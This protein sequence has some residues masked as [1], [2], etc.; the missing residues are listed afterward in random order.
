MPLASKTS[1]EGQKAEDGRHP[2]PLKLW[3]T[4]KAEGIRRLTQIGGDERSPEGTQ[5]TRNGRC[6]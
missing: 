3:R 2:P 5:R 4:G 6:G 1:G